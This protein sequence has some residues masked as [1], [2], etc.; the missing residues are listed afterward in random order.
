[1]YKLSLKGSH[2]GA[3]VKKVNWF[4]KWFDVCVIPTVGYALAWLDESV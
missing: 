4:A 2:E 3:S 1:M